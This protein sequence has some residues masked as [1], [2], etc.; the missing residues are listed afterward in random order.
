MADNATWFLLVC[1]DIHDDRRR[2]R[3]DR[4]LAGCGERVQFSVFEVHADRA[5]CAALLK[6]LREVIDPSEDSVRCYPLCERDVSA[7]RRTAATAPTPRWDYR[8][9]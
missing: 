4:V 2:R 3:V 7:A 5:Q 6:R 1:Y 8:I 9:G